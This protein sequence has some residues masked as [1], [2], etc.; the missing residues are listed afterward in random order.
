MIEKLIE[1]HKRCADNYLET[2]TAKVC[3]CFYCNKIISKKEIEKCGL[4]A[5]HK[6]CSVD[7]VII[8]DDIENKQE[9][10]D[11]MNSYFFGEE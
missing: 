5:L 1:L 9:I 10:L 3:G 6:K 11:Q 8:L 2:L 4:I 7:A